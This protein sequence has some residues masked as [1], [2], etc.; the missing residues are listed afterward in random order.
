AAR[1][2]RFA[3]TG[4]GVSASATTSGNSGRGGGGDADS[5]GM[6]TRRGKALSEA[7]V[8]VGLVQGMCSTAEVAERLRDRNLDVLERE[9]PDFK[10]E[11]TDEAWHASELMIK[12]HQRA[13]AGLDISKPE[14]LRTPEWLARTMDHIVE[15]C[16]DK[17]WE[18]QSSVGGDDPRL[19]GYLAKNTPNGPNHNLEEQLIHE[20]YDFVWNR[21][22]M[23]R[24]DYSMQGYNPIVG[25]SSNSCILVYE[26]I[27]RWYI[28]M[29]NRMAT[30]PVYL[31]QN[32]RKLNLKELVATIRAL[33]SC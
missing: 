25:L 1:E 5:G 31:A 32:C 4:G 10:R 12:K 3:G 26:R 30:N 9:H 33:V 23:V 14:L 17:G 21:T 15:N 11:G 16:V 2:Q 19:I 29:S 22:R 8:T 24:S 28:I 20:L 7:V 13:A 6:V 18:P 27:A